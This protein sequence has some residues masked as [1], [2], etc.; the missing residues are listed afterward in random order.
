MDGGGQ[1]DRLAFRRQRQRTVGDIL[2]GKIFKEFDP[3]IHLGTGRGSGGILHGRGDIAVKGAVGLQQQ[4]AK[5]QA[6]PGR[7]DARL[8]AAQTVKADV[9]G[10][11]LHLFPCGK[12]HIRCAGQDAVHRG[13]RNA[14]SFGEIGDRGAAHGIPDLICIIH[15]PQ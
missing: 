9:F 10:G 6:R 7:R 1:A 3:Q 12:P 2:R 11:P 4:N 15:P 14:G 5:A 8:N 13:D